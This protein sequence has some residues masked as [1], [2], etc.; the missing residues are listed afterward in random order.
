MLLRELQETD[1]PEVLEISYFDGKKAADEAE[2][3]QMMH[4]IAQEY[5]Q[6]NGLNWVIVHT[7]T[8]EIMG[9]CGFAR[10]FEGGTGE[11]GCILKEAFRG[12]GFMQQ[13]LELICRYG[14]EEMKLSRIMAIT[15]QTNS[16]AQAL[17]ERLHFNKIK[18]LPEDALEYELRLPFYRN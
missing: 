1:L 13:A 5:Q 10:G 3:L 16:K 9:T 8:H 18:E 11:A 6:G 14:Q 2:A 15:G 7:A 12:K 4:K 17:L